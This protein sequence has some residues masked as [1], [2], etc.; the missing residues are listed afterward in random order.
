MFATSIQTN[1]QN[2]K[3][4]KFHNVALGQTVTFTNSEGMIETGVVTEVSENKFVLMIPAV[5]EYNGILRFYNRHLAFYKTGTKT[6]VRH[7]H[8]NALEI[9]GIV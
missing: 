3:Q 4:H 2:I 9:T 7:N 1:M 6:H 8:G 5:A